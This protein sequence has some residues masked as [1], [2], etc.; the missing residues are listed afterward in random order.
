M[1]C[2]DTF[3]CHQDRDL[4]VHCIKKIEKSEIRIFFNEKQPEV[5]CRMVQC[6]NGERCVEREPEQPD[7]DYRRVECIDEEPTFPFH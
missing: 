3:E 6:G 1:T 4:R 7:D 5:R 2:P